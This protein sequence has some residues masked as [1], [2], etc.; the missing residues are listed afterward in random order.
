MLN[1]LNTIKYVPLALALVTGV[2]HA[3]TINKEF[4][5][6][7][8]GILKIATDVG[9][10][11]IDTHANNKVLV[12]VEVT[13]KNEDNLQVNFSNSDDKVTIEG[14]YERS[15]FN[16]GSNGIKVTYKVTLPESFNIDLDTKGGSIDIKKLTGEVDAQTSGGS[17]HLEDTHGDINIKTSG[18]SLNL[19]NITG[20]INGHTS[21]GSIK[22]KMPK[23]P[24]GDSKITTSGGSI[25]AY[26]ADDV[27]VDLYAKTSGGSVSSELPVQ[28]KTTKRSINGTLNGGG[29]QLTLKTSGGSVRIKTL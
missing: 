3:K 26:L 27:A 1:P 20:Q 29:P 8:G 16:F 17:I 11:D 21:G 23:S 24:T 15:S 13:G 9:A 12:E 28:G 22:L 5:V 10:I 19:D 25:K 4:S 7:D 2:L 18:G 6:V 14:E